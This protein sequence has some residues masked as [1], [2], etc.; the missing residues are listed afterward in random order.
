[1][2]RDF[3]TL[4]VLEM[5]HDMQALHFLYFI[6]FTFLHLH[7]DFT[8]SIKKYKRTSTS[9]NRSLCTSNQFSSENSF[10]T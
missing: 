1:M 6:L 3:R 10:K 8:F 7:V 2:G 4:R 9:G 5:N